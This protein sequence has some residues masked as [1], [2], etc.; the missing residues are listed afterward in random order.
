[1]STGQKHILLVEDNL[2]ATTVQKGILE[3][4]DCTVDCVD[5]GEKAIDLASKQIYDLILMDLGLPGIDGI[6]ATK[7]IRAENIKEHP[8]HIV[9]IVAVT[10]NE[11]EEEHDK[12]LKNGMSE[13]ICKPFTADKAKKVL[14]HYFKY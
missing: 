14:S 1:M 10:A 6:E 11:N 5:S 3:R 2:V 4:L 12:C 9:P 8:N 7:K 13:V